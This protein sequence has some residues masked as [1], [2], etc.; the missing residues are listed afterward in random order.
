VQLGICTHL[1]VTGLHPAGLFEERFTPGAGMILTFHTSPK[2]D[3]GLHSV[4]LRCRLDGQPVEL[5][6]NRIGHWFS[7]EEYQNAWEAVPRATA[8]AES[9]RE[10]YV[11]FYRYS[12]L[13]PLT[14]GGGP[15]L[16]R[17][18]SGSHPEHFV[19]FVGRC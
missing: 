10:Q 15:N 7:A 17:V 6:Y 16:T 1:G 5:A 12:M 13:L 2:G 18:G 14:V 11:R 8:I 9:V 4:T 3:E 19:C